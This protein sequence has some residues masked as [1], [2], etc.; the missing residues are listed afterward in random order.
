MIVF[1]ALVFFHTAALPSLLRQSWG[2]A[3]LV[4]GCDAECVVVAGINVTYFQV[5]IPLD[6]TTLFDVACPGGQQQANT[7]GT[8]PATAPPAV[9]AAG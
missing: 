9:A 3:I 6:S 2:E 4:A 7:T 8:S 5:A 1:C